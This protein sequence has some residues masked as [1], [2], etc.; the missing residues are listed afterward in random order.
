MSDRPGIYVHVP[1][2][3]RICPYCDF[4]VVGDSVERHRRFT[5]LLVAEIEELEW[6]GSQGFD[7]VYFG[8]GTPSL[9][10]GEDLERIL[11]ALRTHLDCLDL[12]IHLEA[13]PEDVTVESVDGWRQLGVAFLSLGVQALSDERL[14]FLGREHSHSRGPCGDRS[15]CGGWLR[16]P[17]HGPHLRSQPAIN[18]RMGQGSWSRRR[19]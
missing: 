2:C 11:V 5:D 19:R 12:R 6:E 13:N 7:T 8:G 10:A 14:E 4:A 18:G 9:L 17:V 3:R 1:F 16:H 15:S